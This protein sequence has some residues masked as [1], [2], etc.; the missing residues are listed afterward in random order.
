MC[1]ISF[2]PKVPKCGVIFNVRGGGYEPDHKYCSNLVWSGDI[3]KPSRQF[4]FF[5]IFERLLERFL[6]KLFGQIFT[7]IF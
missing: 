2:L 1:A 3:H 7:P 6:D 4:F 5:E